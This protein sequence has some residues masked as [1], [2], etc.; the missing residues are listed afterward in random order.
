MSVKFVEPVHTSMG[1]PPSNLTMNLLCGIAVRV[2]AR[3]VDF[4]GL[5]Y[6]HVVDQGARPVI[7]F[8]RVVIDKPDVD[9]AVERAFQRFGE[10]PVAEFIGTDPQAL[11]FPGVVDECQ[12]R[13]LSV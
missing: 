1:S 11:A 2:L 12:A 5:G 3:P 10:R 9:A 13:L 8:L 6:A 4:S 7:L